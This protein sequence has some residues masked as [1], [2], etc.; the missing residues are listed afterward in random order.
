[1][2]RERGFALYSRP[3]CHLCEDMLAALAAL[4]GTAGVPIEVLDV[5]ADPATRARYGHKIPVLLFDGE[6]VCHGR[7]DAEEVHKALATG[8]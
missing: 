5:D 3:G 6:L 1:M 4:P 7:L 2:S 8:R